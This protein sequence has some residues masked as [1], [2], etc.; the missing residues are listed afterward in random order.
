MK[1]LISF[2]ALST[3]TTAFSLHAA[4]H[5]EKLPVWKIDTVHSGVTFKIRHFFNKVPGS[6]GEFEGEIHFDGEHIDKSKA[7]ATIKPTSVDTNNEDRD[8]HLQNADFF[9]TPEFPEATFE[10]TSWEATGDSTFKIPGNLTLLNTTKEVVL[11]TEFLGT[12]EGRG[13]KIISGWEASATIDRRDIGITYGQG[14][15]GNEVDI[16]LN[17]QAHKQ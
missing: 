16:V 11:E 12:G 1:K 13:G 7:V 3:L 17:I 2:L 14:V 5:G 15:V 10:S 8:E 9:N 4:G 6:F